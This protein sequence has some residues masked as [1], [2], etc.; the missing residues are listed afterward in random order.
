M[1]QYFRVL[2]A[3]LVCSPPWPRQCSQASD[4]GHLAGRNPNMPLIYYLRNSVPYFII[5][6]VLFIYTDLILVIGAVVAGYI[7]SGFQHGFGFSGSEKVVICVCWPCIVHFYIDVST[8]YGIA[9][10]LVMLKLHL[11]LSQFY[12]GRKM[13]KKSANVVVCFC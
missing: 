8:R 6:I 5:S 2:G 10:F 7:F 3:C 9:V 12:N 4:F 11:V 13:K 1:Y